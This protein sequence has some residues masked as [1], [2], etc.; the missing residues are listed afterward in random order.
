MTR[1][2]GLI[3]R[4]PLLVLVNGQTHSGMSAGLSW[5]F[6]EMSLGMGS[7]RWW[8]TPFPKCK[9]PIARCSAQL[10]EQAA[11]YTCDINA[12]GPPAGRCLL[13]NE[14]K[15]KRFSGW[16]GGGRGCGVWPI[17]CERKNIGD[18]WGREVGEGRWKYKRW[19]I[20]RDVPRLQECAQCSLLSVRGN[21]AQ[22]TSPKMEIKPPFLPLQSL[23]PPTSHSQALETHNNNNC[24]NNREFN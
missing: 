18:T 24:N 3:R 5:W 21:K 22:K 7:S 9:V 19:R 12:N 6:C 20:K 10:W 11:H 1:G 4:A 2:W 23:T 14:A 8:P 15:N 13:H 17:G 16:R